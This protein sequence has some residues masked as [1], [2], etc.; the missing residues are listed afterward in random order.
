VNVLLTRTEEIEEVQGLPVND[1]LAPAQFDERA[2]G[3]ETEE[4][5]LVPDEELQQF[6]VVNVAG[7]D[8]PRVASHGQGRVGATFPFRQGCT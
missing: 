6:I 1:Q 5:F 4:S 3:Q 2:L 7:G 8:E